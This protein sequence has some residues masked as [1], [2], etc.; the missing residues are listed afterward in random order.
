MLD[1]N[2]NRPQ[3]TAS[4]YEVNVPENTAAGATILPVSATDR[5]EDSRLFYTIHSFTDLA[6]RTKFKINT[7]TGMAGVTET[8]KGGIDS[9]TEIVISAKLK[10]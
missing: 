7:E 3:F 5:D 9:H 10:T 8:C 2:D 1:I 6:S 4:K